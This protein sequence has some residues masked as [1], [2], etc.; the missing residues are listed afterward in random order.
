MDLKKNALYPILL[1]LCMLSSYSSSAQCIVTVVTAS[2]DT[3]HHCQNAI[4]DIDT[5]SN[6]AN[7]NSNYAYI[8]TDVNNQVVD[9]TIAINVY[10]FENLSVGE[11]YVYGFNYFGTLWITTGTNINNVFAT[12]CFQISSNYIVVYND[13]LPSTANAGVD[14]IVC[15]EE[16]TLSGLPPTIGSG[17]WMTINNNSII[18]FPNQPTSLVNGLTTG[19]YSYEWIVE[20]GGCSGLF[21]SRDTVQITVDTLVTAMAGP[22]IVLCGQSSFMF[23]GND[24]GTAAGLWTQISG[25]FVGI[26]NPTDSNATVPNINFGIYQFEWSINNGTCISRDTVMVTATSTVV[27]NAGVDILTCEVAEL[28]LSGNT[29]STGSGNWTQISGAPTTISNVFDPNAQVSGLT[30]GSYSFVWMVTNGLCSDSDTVNWVLTPLPQGSVTSVFAVSS[31]GAMDGIV[32]VCVNSGSPPF[33]VSLVPNSGSVAPISIFGCANGYRISNLGGGTYDVFIADL[34]NCRDT[35][36]NVMVYEPNCSLFEISMAF[37]SN[38]NCFGANDGQISLVTQGGLLPITFDIGNG[39]PPVTLP[40]HSHDFT[41]LSPGN[42]SQITVTDAAGCVATYPFNLNIA[43]PGLIQLAALPTDETAVGSNDG[44]IDLCVIGG[45]WPYNITISPNV[46]NSIN[47]GQQSCNLNYQFIN[48]PAG[49]Y[50]ITIVDASGCVKVINNIIVSSPS[51]NLGIDSIVVSNVSCSGGSDGSL[52]IYSS[53]ANFYKYSIDGGNS[54]TN[55]TPNSFYFAGQLPSASYSVIVRDN[56]F[57]QTS[58]NSNPIV[59]SDPPLITLNTTITDATGAGNDG[60]ILLCVN[61]GVPNYTLNYTSANNGSGVLT[62]IAG[63]CVG[64]YVLTNLSPDIFNFYVVDSNGCLDTLL[65]Q[66]VNGVNCSSFN[67]NQVLGND[68]KCNGDSTGSINV[69]VAGGLPPYQYQVNGTTISTTNSVSETIN[70]LP[71]G[72]YTV[73]IIDNLS[74]SKSQI[75]IINEPFPLTSTAIPVNPSA[76]GMNDGEICV[77]PTG[78]VVPY[79]VT[80]SCGPVLS[81]GGTGCSGAYHISNLPSGTC[82]ITSVD[83]NNCIVLDTIALSSP[84]CTGFSLLAVNLGNISC[85]GTS[86]GTINIVSNGGVSP[87]SFSIDGGTTFQSSVTNSYTFSNLAPG[88]SNVIIRDGVGCQIIYS[89][90][91]VILTEPGVLSASVVAINPT[92]GSNDGEICISP[93]GGTPPYAIAATCGTVQTGNGANCSGSFSVQNLATGTCYLTITDGNNCTYLDTVALFSANCASFA[94]VSVVANDISCNGLID[95]SITM[96]VSGGVPPYF[97]STNGG[98]TFANTY[99]N[100]FTFPNLADDTYNVVVK[101]DNGCSVTHQANPIVILEPD[102]LSIGGNTLGS[103]NESNTGRID[104]T[105]LGG[106]APYTYQWSNGATSEDQT[107]LAAGTYEVTVCD[108][109]LCCETSNYSLSLLSPVT[110]D[111]GPD[112]AIFSDESV[113]VG[114]QTNAL[115][116]FN[117]I[118]TPAA[119]VSDPTEGIVDL[120]PQ[121][122]TTYTIQVTSREGCLGT[123][124]LIVEVTPRGVFAIPS[125][126]TPN[127][128]GKNETFK[129]IA[130]G[131]N[132]LEYFRIFNRWGELIHN[133]TTP[134]DGAYNG[135]EQPVGTYIY[136]VEFLTDTGERKLEKGHFSLIR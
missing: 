93:V 34:N 119:G 121:Q 29:P 23:S 13:N 50:F 15:G 43:E 88:S 44:I 112:L 87:F 82:Y 124:E 113:N 4:S 83:Q 51:C 127:G 90:N 77:T 105:P 6:S 55:L 79:L 8:I 22:D 120:N 38:V 67:F 109:N 128:D 71:V 75:I 57:C 46:G 12:N 58:Y 80:A 63:P 73:S 114:I 18:Q 31:A 133:E 16:A 81:G 76:V 132:Q 98:F 111:A 102:P 2:S 24:N 129:P 20:N 103:C 35:I 123:D 94:L 96:N 41:N 122:T 21:A 65:S 97:Y 48:L 69:I 17:Q 45:V 9:S 136:V 39:V 30:S 37:V 14:Q 7:L 110:V 74:C 104:I 117:V 56:A 78:G 106:T 84:S 53:G 25:S 101:D 91:P 100:T 134:W 107:G 27:A 33:T 32:D 108:T 3:I 10:D 135:K 19:T 118:W 64:N 115:T 116:P 40:S 5:F 66:V 42:Y 60:S 26:T 72:S 68:V 89:G 85:N 59:I 126:F 36:K 130:L 92:T 49:V 11:Y 28:A 125:G 1:I 54:F 99:A 61:G 70:G 62:S 86:D 131:A 47:Q 52:S 95:G